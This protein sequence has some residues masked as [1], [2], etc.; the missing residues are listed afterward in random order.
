MD[1]G[2][3]LPARSAE[4]LVE[5]PAQQPALPAARQSPDLL[6]RSLEAMLVARLVPSPVNALH[7][8]LTITG[9]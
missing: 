1:G 6:A 7:S 3:Q 2:A 5:L 4:L 8:K 9:M